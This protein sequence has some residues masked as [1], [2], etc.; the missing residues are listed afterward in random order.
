MNGVS[1]K[2][3]GV[4]NAKAFERF[5]KDRE[6][7][8]DWPQFIGPGGRRLNKRAISK[9]CGLGGSIFTQNPRVKARF[10]G[11]TA[12]LL[13]SGI[14][15]GEEDRGHLSSS[16]GLSRDEAVGFIEGQI[17]SLA[18]EMLDINTKLD[19]IT[20]KVADYEAEFQII[21]RSRSSAKKGG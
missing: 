21:I 8:G 10:K 6:K 20:R 17:A 15:K 4:E 9:A 11:L 1:G 12:E 14:L 2:L 13:A 16:T 19:D 5:I 18:T 7:N 3:R